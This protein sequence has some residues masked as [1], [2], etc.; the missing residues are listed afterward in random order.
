MKSSVLMLYGPYGQHPW[1]EDMFDRP[2]KIQKDLQKLGFDFAIAMAAQA[3]SGKD[4]LPEIRIAENPIYDQKTGVLLEAHFKPGTIEDYPSIIDHWVA[5]F[6]DE[7][8]QPDGTYQ[9]TAY[10]LGLPPE[11]LW[12]HKN[13]QTYG[14][15][16]DLMER[17]IEKQ[18]VAIPT[19]S[20]LNYDAF[21]DR[22]GA[23]RELIYKPQ[24]GSRGIGVEVFRNIK[25]LH[26][27]IQTKRIATNGFIQPYLRNNIPIQGVV[28]LTDN[29]A[30]L[31][32]QY[33]TMPDRPREIRMHVI[34]TTDEAGQLRTEAFP[35]MKIS[36]P[37]RKYLKFQL[38]IGL[39]SDNLGP[40]SHIYDATVAM[41]QTVC[42]EAGG[43]TPIP[44]YYGVF[45]W[46]VDGDVRNPEDVYVV[47]GNCRGPGLPV[48][49]APARD[50]LWRALV[51]SGKQVMTKAGK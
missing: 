50:A 45:D 29:D 44:Q 28:P 1:R 39:A 31:L 26:D 3:P 19:F 40:G 8:L 17:I 23:E 10:G 46:L 48:C 2:D 13:I 35:I 36:E 14:N 47:D 25:D 32:K 7:V 5:N 34:T 41:A 42:R 4:A 27:A 20:A 22:Y 30:T 16:K 38:G 18:G 33:N 15:R 24:G 21:V 9:R 11:R 49:A 12:N 6:Q 51:Y 43:D 37:H